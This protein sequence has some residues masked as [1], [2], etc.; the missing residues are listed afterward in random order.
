ME[1]GVR[2][3]ELPLDLGVRPPRGVE[4]AHPEARHQ[5]PRHRAADPAEPHQPG[6]RAGQVEPEQQVGREAGPAPRP[7]QPVALGDPPRRR[8]G[9][10]DAEVRRRVVEDAGGVRDGHPALR[11]GLEVDVVGAHGVVGD[12]AHG[13]AGVEEGRVDAVGG[14]AEHALA[15][16][17][18]RP[19][20]LGRAGPGVVAHGDLVAGGAEA[21]DG[22]RVGQAGGHGEAGHG[23]SVRD[24]GRLP[25]RRRPIGSARRIL[26]RLVAIVLVSCAAAA[27]T[28][29]LGSALASGPAPSRA[30]AAHP[31]HL[32][33]AASPLAGLNRTFR[34]IAPSAR[35][36]AAAREGADRP[37]PARGRAQERGE[38]LAQGAQGQE[39]EAAARDPA[40]SGRAGRAV[41][42]GCASPEP[43][44]AARSRRPR[45]RRRAPRRSPSVGTDFE[46]N[47]S[48]AADG[49]R[50]RARSGCALTNDR[51]TTTSAPDR[52]RTSPGRS[53]IGQSPDASAGAAST[54]VDVTLAAGHVPDL[55]RG[56]RPRCSLGMVVPLTVTP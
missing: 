49:E 47:P 16:G 51:P 3:A 45:R 1:G 53:L 24:P 25:P 42:A 56:P 7:D 41:R 32:S 34:R 15:A 54:S 50:R 40:S 22:A 17:G 27:A 14:E 35:C 38:G 31:A 9:E 11:G 6:R 39:E 48:D 2:H 33:A 55:L 30:Q 37:A 46:F 52:R 36:D 19:Q 18:E 23:G 5:P 28:L 43:L 10:G 12:P 13:R 29:A 26:R 4:A 20:L 44:P 21:L 8:E